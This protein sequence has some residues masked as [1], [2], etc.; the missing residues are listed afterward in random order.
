MTAEHVAPRGA[1]LGN[2]RPVREPTKRG[3]RRGGRPSEGASAAL[4]KCSACWF[5]RI[6]QRITKTLGPEGLILLILLILL[7]KEKR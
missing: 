7:K 2:T 3:F 1:P 5:G 4:A 6:G